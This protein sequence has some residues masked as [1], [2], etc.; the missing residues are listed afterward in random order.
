[1]KKKVV[2]LHP[3]Y[4][5][6]AMGGAELQIYYLIK[7]LKALEYE[8]HYI[9]EDKK[10]FYE[11]SLNL[12]LHPL[13]PLKIKKVF[14]QRWF[15][16]RNRINKKLLHIKPDIIY[17]RLYSSWSGMATDYSLSNNCKHICAVAS[18]NDLKTISNI[19]LFLKPLNIIEKYYVQKSFKRASFVLVQNNYQ[20]RKLKDRF[21]RVGIKVNQSAEYVDEVD[22]VKETSPLNILWI[23]NFKSLKRP[24]LFLELVDRLRDFP[25]LK[26][27]MIG[28]AQSDY[29]RLINQSSSKFKNF[30]YLGEITN[31]EV[32]KEL[33]KGHI[34]VNTSDY[35]GFSNTFVQAW[36]RKVVVLSMNSNPD[37]ILTIKEI[38][39]VCPSVEKLVETIKKLAKED[40]LRESKGQNA[41]KYAV[42]EHRLDKNLDKVISLMS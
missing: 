35:E 27:K 16:Y 29:T 36:M 19:S 5:E 14:G 3:A 20:V 33:L 7:R 28:R 25:N 1:M 6:Q 9:F 39:Y 8:V 23:A 30:E 31:T 24:E 2:I 38:G 15:F 13:D 12:Y 26:F 42:A 10:R 41:Y 32:N 21:N 11:N 34:L 22:I 18:D 4:W 40:D 17:T 37:D